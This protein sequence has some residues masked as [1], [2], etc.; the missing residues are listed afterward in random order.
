MLA[1]K[2]KGILLW[3]FDVIRKKSKEFIH[4]FDGATMKSMENGGYVYIDGPL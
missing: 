4:S 3:C 2:K 1:K